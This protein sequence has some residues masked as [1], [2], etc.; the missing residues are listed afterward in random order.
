MKVAFVT[1]AFSQQMAG[2]AAMALPK[3]MAALGTAEVHV[4]AANLN[5]YWSNPD[6][7]RIYGAFLGPA[8]TACGTSVVDGYTL[9]R[10]PHYRIL[11]QVG[12]RGL[13]RA[14]AA[15]RPDVVQAWM[16]AGP[17]S[18]RLATLKPRLGFRLFTAQ[19]T[20]KSVFPLANAPR[21]GP[22]AWARIFATRFAWGRLVSWMSD[23]CYPATVDCGEV[24]TR[25][26]G[27]QPGKCRIRNLGV[28]SDIFHPAT[29]PDELAERAR[30][31]GELGFAP[32]DI[33]CLYTGR[34][35]ADKD[36]LCLARAIDRLRRRG[37]PF[38]G[39]FIGDG[40]QLDEIGRCA[41]CHRLPFR[42]YR[43]L[44]PF[45]RLA[46]VGVWPTQESTSMLDAAASGLPIVVSDRLVARERIDGN[47]LTHRQGDADDLADVLATLA[48]A[49]VR[50]RLGA[51]GRQRMVDLFS[52]TAVARRTLDDFTR[53][54]AGQR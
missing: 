6:Y 33:V 29:T 31:R 38:A 39:L 36:P 10:L 5:V 32:G 3:A 21:V 35:A 23:G 16:P 52:W 48:P 44:P 40:P 37:L 54:M 51:T 11:G 47:G 50:Q 28:D 19:H 14:L 53:T 27:V 41:G 26:M 45:Y 49:E 4:V 9:H 30:R 20:T 15:I 12:I 2:Y 42:D 13:R 24:A 46:D 43:E 8:V 7:E 22:L 34:L 17:V 18:L 25:F 1:T